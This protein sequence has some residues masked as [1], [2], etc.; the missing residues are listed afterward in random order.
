MQKNRW[1]CI[2]LISTLL[3]VLHGPL[4]NAEDFKRDLKKT[5][6]AQS[7]VAGIRNFPLSQTGP[8]PYWQ[9]PNSPY[10]QPYY[11]YYSPP[12][13]GY[14]PGSGA[15]TSPYPAE[16][17]PAGRLFI[18]I[19]PL[20]AQVMI[21]GYALRQKDDLTYEAGLFTGTHHVEAKR[22]GFKPYKADVDIQ[23]GMGT[24]ITIV[25]EKLQK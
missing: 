9:N 14:H 8:V 23:P 2:L 11:P 25:L 12:Y 3:I 21:D 13:G 6:I 18:Q 5:V 1:Q 24:L 22:E 15:D 10:Y 4:L 19:E 16:V 20:D 17:K 7:L